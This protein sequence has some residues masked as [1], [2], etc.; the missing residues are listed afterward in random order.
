[1]DYTPR[2]SSGSGV[3]IDSQQISDLAFADDVVRP[4]EAKQR[5]Q[6][7]LDAIDEKAKKEG[8]TVNFSR[9]KSMANFI[10][11]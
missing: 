4:E 8:L 1:M 9:I 3:K 6:L 5:P 7:L 2:Q 10:L 11:C